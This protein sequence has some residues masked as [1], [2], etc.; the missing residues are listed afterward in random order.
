MKEIRSCQD[1]SANDW[2]SELAELTPCNDPEQQSDLLTKWAKISAMNKV[3]IKSRP[4][5]SFFTCKCLVL[6]NF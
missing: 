6:K 3:S 5:L 1:L 4:Y 2:A